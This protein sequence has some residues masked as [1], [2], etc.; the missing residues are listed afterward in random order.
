MTSRVLIV[1][2]DETL[3][4]VAT[5]QLGR[6]GFDVNVAQDGKQAVQVFEEFRPDL[7]LMDI[8]MPEMDGL[9]AAGLMRGIQGRDGRPS[10][11]VI[12]A[13]TAS[14]IRQV[15]IEAGLDDYLFKPFLFEELKELLSKWVEMPDVS[16]S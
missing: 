2:D 14:K 12:I 11:L 6:L 4:L 9:E 16:P 10:K 7:V 5:R 1:D 15:V 8:H 3:R 13:M